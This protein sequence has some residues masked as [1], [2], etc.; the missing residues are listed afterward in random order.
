M[1]VNCFELPTGDGL[2]SPTNL[3]EV[4]TSISEARASS[5]KAALAIVSIHASD[6]PVEAVLREGSFACANT[7]IVSKTTHEKS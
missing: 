6:K 4:P 5:T 2:P 3:T 7:G 1:V